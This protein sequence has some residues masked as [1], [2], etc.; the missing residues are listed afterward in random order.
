MHDSRAQR[1]YRRCP[2][3]ALGAAVGAGRQPVSPFMADSVTAP[4]AGDT[5]VDGNTHARAGGGL[6]GLALGSIG[7]VYGDIGTSPLYAF[8]EAIIASAGPHHYEA[9]RH[10]EEM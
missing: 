10:G 1:V 2:A 7:V 6:L 9:L 8:R 5:P 3:S 4:V